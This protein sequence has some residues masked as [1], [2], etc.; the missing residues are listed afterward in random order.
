MYIYIY[1][2]PFFFFYFSSPEEV[3]NIADESWKLKPCYE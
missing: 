1:I 2:F 3:E